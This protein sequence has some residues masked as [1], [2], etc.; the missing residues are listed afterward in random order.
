M[1]RRPFS[2]RILIR[3]HLLPVAVHVGNQLIK[4]PLHRFPRLIAFVRLDRVHDS[5]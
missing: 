2:V 1:T 5:S 4:V 3:K